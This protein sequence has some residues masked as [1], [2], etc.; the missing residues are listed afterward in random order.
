MS[1]QKEAIEKLY[2]K[3]KTFKIPKEERE[4]VEQIDIEIHPLSLEEMSLLNMGEE[5]SLS[6]L[7]KNTKILF[8]KSLRCTEDEAA[9]ISVDFMA[10]LLVAVMDVNKLNEEDLKKAGIKEFIA[11]KKEQIK[12]KEKDGKFAKQT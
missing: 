1:S 7:A 6:E 5:L 10:D 11:K 8:A 3:G 4:G 12:E 2:A 9:K